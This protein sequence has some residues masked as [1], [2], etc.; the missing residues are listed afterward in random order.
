MNDCELVAVEVIMTMM[1]NI[2]LKEAMNVFCIAHIF[3]TGC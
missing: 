1:I 3:H 2:F